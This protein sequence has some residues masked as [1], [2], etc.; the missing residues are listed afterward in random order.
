MRHLFLPWTVFA[1]IAAVCF[2]VADDRPKSPARET[3]LAQKE[4]GQKAPV[5]KEAAPPAKTP[6][7]KPA[8]APKRS[9]DEEA[10]AQAA[11]GLG[12]AY[13]EHNGKNFAA[14]FTADG[15]YVDE[16]GNVFHGR[17][18]IEDEF[19]ALLKANPETGIELALASLRTIA[20]GVIAADGT[21]RLTRKKGEPAIAGRCSLV[22]TKDGNKWLI[23][24]LRE[25]AD[26]GQHA[27]HHEQVRQ[28]EFLIGDWVNQGGHSDVHFTCRWDE[29]MNFLVRDFAVHVA[30]QKTMTGTQRIGYDPLT[31]HLRAWIF[32]S[33]GGYADGYFHHDG[34]IWVLK[35]TGVTAD[36][37]MA[38]GTQL[39]GPIDAHRLSWK[40]V[41]YVIGGE[42]LPDIPPVTI[43]RKPPAPI[44]KAE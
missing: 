30:G 33:A 5:K 31:G 21:T 18:A 34:E 15:E 17:K 7:A 44:T 43:V 16:N 27:S 28:L 22:C 39:F 11:T 26:D 10:V 35:T 41:D 29:G 36:G 24:S 14:A 13:N 12:K 19:A 42:Q 32:D 3:A 9:P 4:T 8:P 25:I 20:P 23:A 6:S 2:V 1:A 40:A 37:Q 38:S